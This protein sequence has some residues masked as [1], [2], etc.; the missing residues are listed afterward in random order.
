LQ[1][2]LDD[3]TASGS[4][5]ISLPNAQAIKGAVAATAAKIASPRFT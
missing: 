4:A 5:K 3:P 2:K 1:T